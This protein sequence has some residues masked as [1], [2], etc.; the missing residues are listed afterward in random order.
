MCVEKIPGTSLA[1]FPLHVSAE[2][3]KGLNYGAI[4]DSADAAA[5]VHCPQLEFEKSKKTWL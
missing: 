3:V 4:A 2:G 1:V 5:G